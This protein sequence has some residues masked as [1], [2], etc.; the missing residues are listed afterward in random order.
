MKSIADYLNDTQ[1]TGPAVGKMFGLYGMQIGRFIGAE[2]R[3]LHLVFVHPVNGRMDVPIHIEM[4]IP[5][6]INGGNIEGPIMNPVL[7][8]IIQLD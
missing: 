3:K 7:N 8:D 1:G 5:I 2:G 6:R 4:P